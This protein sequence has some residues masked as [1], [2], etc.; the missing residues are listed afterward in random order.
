[1][2]SRWIGLA[3]IGILAA[4]PA[5]RASADDDGV[6]L[7]AKGQFRATFLDLEDNGKHVIQ[8]GEDA[9]Y[10]T[11]QGGGALDAAW[12]ALNLQADFAGEGSLGVGSSDDTYQNSYGGGLHVGWRDP[13]RGSFGAFGTMGNVQTTETLGKNP[14]SVAFGAGIEGQLFLDSAT[15]YLQAGYLDRQTVSSGGDISAMKNA[16]FG[17]LVGRYFIGDHLKLEPEVSYTQG[18]MDPDGDKIW[19]LGWGTDIEYQLCNSPVSGFVAYTG[20]RYDQSDDNDVLFEHRI[21][22]GVRVYFGQKSLKA[23]DRHGVSL[24][25][26]RYL[27]WQGQIAGPLE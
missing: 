3:A 1:M 11:L 6:Q 18:K 17:R 23:N 10:W 19:V 21:G 16:G 14:D 12:R 20:A 13:E 24:D 22:F 5:S 2:L 25:L 26:P 7:S 27:E 15:L 4:Y 8:G 9:H